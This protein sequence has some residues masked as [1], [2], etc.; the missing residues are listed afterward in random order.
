MQQISSPTLKSLFISMLVSRPADNEIV[1]IATGTAFTVKYNHIRYLITNKHN[2][3]GKDSRGNYISTHGC[4]PVQICI[5]ARNAIFP[6]RG[7]VR[8]TLPLYDDIETMTGPKWVS[9]PTSP[10]Y[11]VVAIPLHPDG[12][13]GVGDM[14]DMR[15][16]ETKPGVDVSYSDW[17]LPPFLEDPG[18]ATPF[19]RPGD[20]VSI[21]GFPFGLKTLND[22]PIWV[23]GTIATEP[24]FDYDSNPIFLVDARTRSGQSGSPV[25][26]HLS[27]NSPGIQF[28]DY[29]VRTFTRDVGFLLG[30]YSGRV[31]SHESDLGIVWKPSVIRE[32][33]QSIN[34]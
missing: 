32:I 4:V 1:E 9:H 12:Y 17:V 34:P 18:I 29:S 8:V 33:L 22:F 30:V 31:Q 13:T 28:T 5:Y 3:T 27:V 21:I 16:G 19:L 26:L 15:P 14:P 7:P 23:N 24:R 10:D 11:D 6:D 25:I 2:V 20:Q